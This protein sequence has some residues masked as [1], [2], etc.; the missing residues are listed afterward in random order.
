MFRFQKILEI[1]KTKKNTKTKGLKI[2]Q[3]PLLSKI[4]DSSKNIENNGE[5]KLS[6]GILN[7]KVAIK[8]TKKLNT[9]IFII[10][11][12]KNIENKYAIKADKDK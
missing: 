12:L 7:Q 1:K 2:L 11:F 9:K 6:P 8:A 4:V 10:L 3:R 5:N